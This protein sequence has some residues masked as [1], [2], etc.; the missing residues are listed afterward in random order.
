MTNIDA[1]RP[2]L[3]RLGVR[4]RPVNSTRSVEAELPARSR[5]RVAL[6]PVADDPVAQVGAAVAQDPHR[7]QHV[8][9][10]LA[11]D[12]LA[13]GDERRRGGRPALHRDQVGAEVDDARRPAPRSRQARS[14]P[15]ELAMTMRA[16]RKARRHGCAPAGVRAVWKTSPPCSE[17]TSGVAVAGAQQGVGGGH[18]VVRVEHVIGELATDAAQLQRQSGRGER[19]PAR[20]AASARWGDERQVADVEAVELL[21]PGWLSAARHASGSRKRAAGAIGRCRTMTR[22]SAP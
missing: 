15:I 10:A 14:I 6:R 9:L 5:E 18:R 11:R 13:D 19:A 20:V 4:Q 3:Q 1:S 17:M 22:T 16:A 21:R 2:R 7:A 8:G 12:Q